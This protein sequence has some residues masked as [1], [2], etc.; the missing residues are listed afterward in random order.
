MDR[1]ACDHRWPVMSGTHHETTKYRDFAAFSHIG[2]LVALYV[3]SR[4]P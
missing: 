2:M 4:F 1:R 3:A